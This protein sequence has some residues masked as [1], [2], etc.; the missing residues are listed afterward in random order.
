MSEIYT[1]RTLEALAEG[2]YAE[3]GSKFLASVIP[4][5]VMEEVQ[6][7]LDTLRVLHPKARH[8]CYAWRMLEGGQL[9]EYSTDA[10]EPGG[11]AGLPVLNALRSAELINVV[12]IVV[13]YYGGT[14]LGIPGL[15]HAYRTAAEEAL[16]QAKIISRTRTVRYRLSMPMALQPLFLDACK[17]MD[18]PTSGLHY[19]E[20]F[21]VT[22]SCPMPEHEEQLQRLLRLVSQRDFASLEEYLTHLG[23]AMNLNTDTS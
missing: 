2:R 20:R 11:S 9:V 1:Y 19:T 8:V 10:G 5:Q 21:E 4:V 16:T 13:R 6:D 12:A 18:V 23:I 22:I 7:A 14:K 15:I 3:K 17:R